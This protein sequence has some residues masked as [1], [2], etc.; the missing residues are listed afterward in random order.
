MNLQFWKKDEAAD[1]FK[2]LSDDFV[3]PPPTD[4]PQQPGDFGSQSASLGTGQTMPSLSDASAALSGTG[5]M[6][7]APNFNAT[8]DNHPAN[9][10]FMPDGDSKHEA[11]KDKLLQELI[12]ARL[13]SIK[14][15]LE[16]LNQR[17]SNLEKPQG[18]KQQR[19]PWYANQ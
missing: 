16:V 4:T 15:Q 19:G 5:T 17:V 2:D 9:V 18:Q 6:P 3:P 13:D 7:P 1:P 8:P 12:L 10:G 14:N 11:E